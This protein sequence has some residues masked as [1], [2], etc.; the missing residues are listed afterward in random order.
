VCVCVCV[1]VSVSVCVRARPRSGALLV[2]ITN[3]RD[4]RG[5]GTL[6]FSYPNSYILV[7]S[8]NSYILGPPRERCS[9]DLG[10]RV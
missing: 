10:F 2:V 9:L 7:P 5:G 4:F 3:W 8:R 6:T 1:C